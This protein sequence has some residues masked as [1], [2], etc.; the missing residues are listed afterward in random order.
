MDLIDSIDHVD[1]RR[2]GEAV[3]AFV[4]VL[5]WPLGRAIAAELAPIVREALAVRPESTGP[6]REELIV[7]L[8]RMTAQRDDLVKDL[9]AAQLNIAAYQERLRRPEPQRHPVDKATDEDGEALPAEG[10]CGNCYYQSSGLCSQ[11]GNPHYA[12][13]V[14]DDDGCVKHA[15]KPA[16]IARTPPLDL[17]LAVAPKCE[18]CKSWDG[19]FCGN[20]KS[21]KFS[22]Q[23]GAANTCDR[24]E[25]RPAG[26]KI[27]KKRGRPRKATL[28]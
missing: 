21:L 5:A 19:T 20:N 9:A 4:R 3:A 22:L 28:A 24:F 2:D 17:P 10:R 18:N 12:C 13:S 16:G 27:A 23:V 11:T 25:V 15:F 6:S 8:A 7:Q 26:V 1:E 14:D